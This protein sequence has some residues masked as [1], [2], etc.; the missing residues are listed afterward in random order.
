[1]SEIGPPSS[2]KAP[3]DPFAAL[4]LAHRFGLS[5]EEIEHAFLARMGSVHPDVAGDE[6]S[7]DAAALIAAR[8]TLLNPETRADAL[9]GLLGGPAASAERSLPDGFLMEMMQLRE[10]VEE[11]LA[12]GGDA[13][14]RWTAFAQTRRAE[15]GRRVAELFE[16]AE[17]GRGGGDLLGAVRVELNAWRYTERLIEQLDPA[18]DPNRADFAG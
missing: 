10:T 2:R 15:H 4:G 1:M 17:A 16:A 7:M 5:D 3:S 11:D 13:R 12:E 14:A 18:Y 8:S 9:L 6:G